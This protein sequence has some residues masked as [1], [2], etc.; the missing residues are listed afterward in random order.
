MCDDRECDDLQ[1]VEGRLRDGPGGGRQ[2]HREGK[3]QQRRRQRERRERQEC[4]ERTGLRQAD[5]EAELA[6]RRARKKLT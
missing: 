6:G 4:A 3:Q 2:E 5:P 1:P